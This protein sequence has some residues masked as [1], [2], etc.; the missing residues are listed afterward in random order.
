MAKQIQPEDTFVFYFS[1]HSI[2][3]DGSSFLLVAN[4]DTVTREP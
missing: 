3:N 2:V 1:G 4:S